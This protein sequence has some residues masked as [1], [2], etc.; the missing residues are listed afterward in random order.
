ML[1][2]ASMSVSTEKLF[3]TNGLFSST[4][5]GR[6]SE[7]ISESIVATVARLFGDF[8]LR[9]ASDQSDF[10]NISANQG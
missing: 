8:S 7:E 2:S 10:S 6:D 4:G 5:V 3:T 9:L 1:L